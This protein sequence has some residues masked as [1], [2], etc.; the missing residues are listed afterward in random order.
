LA[1]GLLTGKYRRGRPVPEGTRI[2]AGGW[3]GELLTDQNLALVEALDQFARSHGRTLLELAV[4]WLL[5]QRGVVSV[6]AGA[7]SPRQVRA[8]SAAAGWKLTEADLAAIDGIVAPASA[9]PAYRSA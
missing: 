7:T 9:T 5:A 1:S 6:I 2:A 3:A 4:S 8:N